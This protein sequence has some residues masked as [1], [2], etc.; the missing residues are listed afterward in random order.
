[1]LPS[2][3]PVGPKVVSRYPSAYDPRLDLHGLKIQEAFEAVQE[4]LYQGFHNGF[5]K[6]TVIS[7]RSGQ[8]N[9]EIPR[10]LENNSYVRSINSLRGG[11]AWEVC[12]K[13]RDM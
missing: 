12:L 10:W 6:V 8:I 13:K 1:M 3:G 5:K 4:H 9:Q 7:G 11:G 2:E